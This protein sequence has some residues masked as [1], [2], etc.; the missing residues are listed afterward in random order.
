[1]VMISAEELPFLDLLSPSSPAEFP[2][3]VDGLHRQGVW[4]VATPLGFGVIEANAVRD[5][6]RDER[7]R[8][9]GRALLELQGVSSGLL[10]E[11]AAETILAKEGEEHKR[12]RRL[13]AKAF[14]PPAVERLR[15]MMRAHLKERLDEVV[16]SGRCEVMA[17]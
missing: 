17:D 11:T 4:V 13:V 7:L 8:P 6:Q 12:L 15:P 14:T 9:V 10:Y 5:L 16:P 2:A 3:L 1:M